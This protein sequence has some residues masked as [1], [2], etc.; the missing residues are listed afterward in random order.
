M[1]PGIY[2][3]LK[4]KGIAIRLMGNYLRICAGSETENAVVLEALR[5]YWK[6]AK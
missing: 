2:H 1:Q 6:G 3:A 4:A 5:A